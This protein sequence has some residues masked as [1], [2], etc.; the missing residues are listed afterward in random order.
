MRAVRVEDGALEVGEIDAPDLVA[1][2]LRVRV[3]AAGVNRADL[4]KV[5]TAARWRRRRA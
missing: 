2:G 5:F 1:G 4:M 3:A